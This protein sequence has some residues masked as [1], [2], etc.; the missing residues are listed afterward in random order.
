MF[1]QH[2]DDPVW[3]VELFGQWNEEDS[4]TEMFIYFYEIHVI[5]S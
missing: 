1:I 4:Q 2:F 5:T 3:V